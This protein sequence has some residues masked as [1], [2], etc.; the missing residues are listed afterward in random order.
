MKVHFIEAHADLQISL[1]EDLLD[2]LPERICLSTTSQFIPQVDAMRAQLEQK[3][4]TTSLLSALHSKHKGQILGCGFT[5]FKFPD[6][7]AFLYVGDGLFH[8][9]AL[10]LG[11]EVPVFRYDPFIEKWEEVDPSFRTKVEKQR[12][13]G[14]STF[15]MKDNIGIIISTKPGQNLMKHAFA[16]KKQYPDKNFYFLV[17]ST[18][19]FIQLGNFPFIECF[20][21][22]ACNRLQ[23]DYDKFPKPMVNI[24]DIPGN[25][26]KNP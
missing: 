3:G 20:V 14:L 9:K 8:P 2:T 6:V 10:L 15:L 21:N 17:T 18:L 1:P 19:D 22:T 24:E 7:D 12:K 25:T 13:V 26:I 23:D 5:D 4:K 11:T 16:L